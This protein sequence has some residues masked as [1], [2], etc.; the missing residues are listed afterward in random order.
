VQRA[1]QRTG[2]VHR[3]NRERSSRNGPFRESSYR[4]MSWYE[5]S[6]MA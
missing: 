4:S 6:A 3:N 2:M 5:P 1:A